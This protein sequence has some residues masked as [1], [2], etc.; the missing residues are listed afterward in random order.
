V[1]LASYADHA[2]ALVNTLDPYRQ[3]DV[4]TTVAEARELLTLTGHNRCRISHTDVA[5]LREL[6]GTLREIFDDV[7]ANRVS[8]A[9]D[10][11][12]QLL[13]KYPIRPLITNHEGS[14]WHLH[15]AEGASAAAAFSARACVGLAMQA[16]EVGVDR[17]GVCQA[18]PC[19]EVFIDTSTNRSRRYCSDRCATRA[20]VA[21]YRA[22]RKAATAGAQL[23]T[24]G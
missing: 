24:V 23:A 8:H 9:V 7:D 18:V 6:R 12:N 20:N 16:T 10:L 14:G 3:R 2:V 17:L 4:L 19:R 11:L 1:E 5:E 13:V 21:A 15:L 22:R